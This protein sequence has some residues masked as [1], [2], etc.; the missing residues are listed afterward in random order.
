MKKYKFISFIIAIVLQGTM[1]TGC[2]DAREIDDMAYP[3]ALGFDKGESNEL[4][5]TLQIAVPVNIAGGEGGGG[6]D[7]EKGVTVVTVDTPSI[8]SG[9]SMLNT[10][11]SKQ[12]NLSH[13]KAIVFSKEIAMEGVSKYLHAMI[14]NREFRPNARVIVSRC[15]A[16]EFISA[17]KPKLETNPAKYYELLLSAY[18]YTGFSTDTQLIGFYNKTESDSIQAVAVLADV[19]EYESSDEFSIDSSTYKQKGRSYPLEGDFKAGDLPK[20]GE[21]NI[22]VMGLAVFNGGKMVGELDGEETTYHLMLEGKFKS[23]LFTMPDPMDSENFI[24]LNIMKSRKT[25]KKVEMHG[26]KPKLYAKV[27]LEGDILSIQKGTNYEN[28]KNT[29]ML[30]EATEIFI[31]EGVIKYLDKSINVFGTDTNG[32]GK[33]YKSKFLTWNDWEQFDW[34][35]KYKQSNYEIDI[36]VNIRRPGLITKT[37]PEV[38]GN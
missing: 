2:Y 8:Y 38:I 27:F 12:I 1:L 7:G 37:V 30:E 3:I 35:T 19:S 11:L 10:F 17:V 32:F 6:G 13:L 33:Q 20:T 14:R 23:M 9:L 16:E 22:E 5:M 36:D 21:L 28:E 34:L 29:P 4:R 31:K 24:V 25:K 26:D 15:P 18:K